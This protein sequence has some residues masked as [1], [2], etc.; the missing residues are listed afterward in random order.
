MSGSTGSADEEWVSNCFKEMESQLRVCA[1]TLS[2]A[3]MPSLASLAIQYTDSAAQPTK[4]T[5][6]LDTFDVLER[7]EKECYSKIQSPSGSKAVLPLLLCTFEKTCLI[8]SLLSFARGPLPEDDK[9]VFWKLAIGRIDKAIITCGAGDVSD[10]SQELIQRIQGRYLPLGLPS[11]LDNSPFPIGSNACGP[12]TAIMAVLRLERPS[13]SAYRQHWHSPFVSPSYAAGWPA[14]T[15]HPWNLPAYLKK[16]AGRGRM[17]PVEIGEDYRKDDWNQELMDW[18]HLLN[19]LSSQNVERNQPTVYLAQHS[20]FNQFPALRA[21]IEV[22]PYVYSVPPVPADYPT[23]E[24]PTND[25]QLVINTWIGPGG[26]VSPAHTDPYYNCYVQIVGRK[27]VWLAPP[28]ATPWMYPHDLSLS[29]TSQVDVFSVNTDGQLCSFPLFHEHIPPIAQWV[30]LGPGDLLIFP[31]GWWHAM[32]SEDVS[33]S[34][35][36]WF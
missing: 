26:T 30:T 31:P 7:L 11:P 10:I 2:Q 33:V 22:P 9:E 15:S 5:A 23:Y 34:L 8:L 29:N 17:V 14:M 19:R 4:A 12:P 20:L 35:S 21:D 6:E 36:M 27:T 18:E 3:D 28:S 32:R 13:M 24:P 1:D 16:V 25:E